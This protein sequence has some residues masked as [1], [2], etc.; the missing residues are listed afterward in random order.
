M[1]VL[2]PVEQVSTKPPIGSRVLYSTSMNRERVAPPIAHVMIGAPGGGK[3]TVAAQLGVLFDS[4]ILSTDEIRK[5]LYGD[6]ATQGDWFQIADEL[7]RRAKCAFAMGRNVIIDATHAKVRYRRQTISL[8]KDIGFSTIVPMLIHPNLDE[9]LERNS[10]RE[11]RVPQRVVIQMWN[12][13]EA[14][15]NNIAKEFTNQ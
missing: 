3:S 4:V 2:V 9:C 6:E 5:S 13:I 7:K 15:K 1:S 14:S 12:A 10:K 11:R 8:L